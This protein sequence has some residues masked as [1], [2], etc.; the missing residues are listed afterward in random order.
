MILHIHQK[1]LQNIFTG[2]MLGRKRFHSIS[3]RHAQNC[4]TSMMELFAETVNGFQQKSS[5]LDV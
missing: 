3:Q 4:Q 1:I 5:I 2:N